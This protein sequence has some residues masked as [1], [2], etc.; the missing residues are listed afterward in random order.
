MQVSIYLE[1]GLVHKI[2]REARLRKQTRSRFIQ[3]ILKSLLKAGKR[4]SPWEKAFG[5]FSHE[6]HSP[7]EM[8]AMIRKSRKNRSWA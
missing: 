8:V 5:M 1:D 4:K 7:E 3:G 6:S 2:D